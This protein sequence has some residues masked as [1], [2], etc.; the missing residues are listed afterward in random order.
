M[1]DHL[2]EPPSAPTE[3]IAPPAPPILAEGSRL[4]HYV[5]EGILGRGGMGVVYGARDE[6]LDRQVA[7][8]RIPLDIAGDPAMRERRARE[9]R[10]QAAIDHPNVATIYALEEEA[11]SLFLV[12]QRI[13]GSELERLLRTG[14]DLPLDNRLKIARQLAAALAAAH[15][16][17][18]I[19]CDLKPGNVMVTTDGETKVLDFGIARALTLGES[20]RM[21]AAATDTP[22]DELRGTPGF[23]SP[24][25]ILGETVDA[26]T[27][28]F[29]FGALLFELLSGKPAFPGSNLLAV[30][31]ATLT[32]SPQWSLLPASTPPEVFA[33]LRRCLSRAKASR[34]DMAVV[35]DALATAEEQAASTR[36]WTTENAQAAGRALGAGEKAPSFA[37]EGTEGQ[38]AS[39]DLL[40]RGALA[41]LFYRGAW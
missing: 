20:G 9:A 21:R 16:A 22:P 41:I 25:Q 12:I 29:A 11:G 33:I 1:E 5:I 8:K 4:G 28:V 26:R 18:V 35:R 27:D 39:A 3:P 24:E 37:L 15:A 34:P 38:V 2:P 40:A 36:R 6:K 23:M 13:E 31:D 17:G 10:L 19:H 7:I 14:A 30:L 32:R